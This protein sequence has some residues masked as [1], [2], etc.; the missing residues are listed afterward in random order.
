MYVGPG[1]FVGQVAVWDGAK[2]VPSTINFGGISGGYGGHRIQW[3]NVNGN[4]QGTT[5]IINFG[6]TNVAGSNI[7]PSLVRTDTFQGLTWQT[8]QAASTVVNTSTFGRNSATNGLALFFG[9]T[10]GIGGFFWHGKMGYNQ[11]FFGTQSQIMMM[12]NLTT[13]PGA[14]AAP[15]SLID[16]IGLGNDNGDA[17]LQVMNN[18]AAGACTKT[19]LGANFPVGASQAYEFWFYVPPGGGSFSYRVLNMMTG[20]DTGTQ[21]INSNLPTANIDLSW[22]IYTSNNGTVATATM[23]WGSQWIDCQ[24]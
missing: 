4:A 18:D 2:W 23:N 20:A 19:D 8:L 17:H 3:H 7:S 15:S 12:R 21:T 24:S 6:F 16:L 22:Q 9:N 13:T 11:T 10:S 14:G 5:N 1:N